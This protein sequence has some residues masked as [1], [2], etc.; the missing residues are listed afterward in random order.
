MIRR[1]DPYNPLAPSPK[2]RWLVVWDMQFRLLDSTELAPCTDL[3]AVMAQTAQ[4]WQQEGWTV[5]S[6]ARYGSFFCHRA[7]MRRLIAISAA[8]PALPTG[9]GPSW[10]DACPTCNE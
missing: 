7:G 5:E 10:H 9:G 8:D 2:P 1:R 4:R 6:D 3:A